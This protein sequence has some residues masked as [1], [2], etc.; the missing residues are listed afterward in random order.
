MSADNPYRPDL[1]EKA[2]RAF[3]KANP[4]RY[5]KVQSRPEAT[6]ALRTLD[7]RSA[8]IKK[9]MRQHFRKFQEVWVA[10]EAINIW[11]KRSA[12]KANHPAPFNYFHR[13][14]AADVIMKQARRNVQ[15]RMSKRLSRVNK[16]KTRMENN[17]VRNQNFADRDKELRLSR[18]FPKVS[19]QI[20]KRTRKMS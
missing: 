14:L 9:S 8:H 6:A 10:R 18:V 16:I 19:G 5:G 17:V 12:L 20:Q 13:S 1:K 3:A 4:E 15:V 11:Q 2:K 7:H